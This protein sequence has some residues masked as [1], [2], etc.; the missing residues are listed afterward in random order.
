MADVLVVAELA[1]GQIRKTT[2]SAITMAKAAA[3]VLGG[4]FDILVIG[5]PGA[6]AAAAGATA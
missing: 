2:L 6:K 1:D 5:G 4:G 3:A